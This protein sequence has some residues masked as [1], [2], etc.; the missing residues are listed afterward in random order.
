MVLEAPAMLLGAVQEQVAEEL[1]P[2]PLGRPRRGLR[3]CRRRALTNRH[4]SGPEDLEDF[5]VKSNQCVVQSQNESKRD[6]G[7]RAQLRCA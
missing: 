7:F 2:R 6:P 5:E 3:R 1:R 4:A